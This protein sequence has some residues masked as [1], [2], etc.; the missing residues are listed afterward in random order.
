[1]NDLVSVIVPYFQKKKYF[2]KSINSIFNQTYK[3]LE[4]IIIYDDLNKDDLN[5]IKSFKNKKIKTRIIINRRN[6]G[7]GKSRNIGMKKSKGKYIA[8]LDS[9]DYWKKDK[10]KY[11]LMFMKKN[12]LSFSHTNYFLVNENDKILGLM[13]V[14]KN[15]KYND[16]IKS[17]DIGTSTVMIKKKI[18]KNFFFFDFKTKEDYFLWLKIAKRKIDING[19]NKNLVFWRK[20]NN[21]LSS[22]FLQKIADA[23]RV[24][25]STNKNII[26]SSFCVIRLSFYYIF[27][28]LKQ[29]NQFFL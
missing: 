5:F 25:Y 23:Y 4:I 26:Y 1:M 21:S 18:L 6:L 9:D 24:Y 3:N 2:T 15:L 8:F 17:C 10:I 22:S 11:Q 28:K 27:K 7:V 29:K 13:K 12:N 14:K 20:T 16:L 19:I